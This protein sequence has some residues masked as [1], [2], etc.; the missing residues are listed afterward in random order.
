MKIKRRDF[1]K[2]SALGMGGVL[3]G[4]HLAPSAET[5]PRYFDPYDSITLGKTKIKM[6][7]VCLGTGMRGGNRESNQTRMG[8]DKLE[9]LI[10]CSYERG[11]R[12][13]DLADLYGTHQYLL[14][15]LK[16]LPRD[17]YQVITKIWWRTGGIPE[18]ERPDADMVIARFLKELGTD[19]LRSVLPFRRSAGSRRQ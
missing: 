15:A 10:R 2:Q 19:S 4:A 14:P 13:F 16:G 17:N 1:L 6:S 12:V 9:T 5:K 18:K 7:R 11:V 3:A 8:K